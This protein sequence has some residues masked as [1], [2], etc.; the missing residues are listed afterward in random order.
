[1]EI[2]VNPKASEWIL[3][4]PWLSQFVNNCI[5]AHKLPYEILSYL[6]GT[7]T[8][9]T[10]N[11]GFSWSCTPEGFNFWS[12]IDDKIIDAR[13]EENWDDSDIIIDI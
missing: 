13:A 4:Q 8:D 7:N 3:K 1:M 10:V 5:A 12:D 11:A 2:F 6:L 9:D